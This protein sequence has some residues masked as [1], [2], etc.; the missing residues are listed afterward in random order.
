MPSFLSI[1]TCDGVHL[2]HQKIIKTLVRESRKRDYGGVLVYFPL[3]PKFVFSGETEN[4]LITLPAERESL[5][6]KAGAGRVV[7]LPFDR[8]L[9]VM[10]AES[11]FD[12]VV[13]GEYGA[14]GLVMGRDF[15][16]GKDRR[17]NAEFLEKRCA[18]AGI[19]FKS[20]HFAVHGGHK[21]SSSL[22]RAYLH[23]GHVEEA[24]KCLGRNYSVSGKVVKGAGI[25]RT[26]GFPTANIAADPAKILPP[27]VYAAKAHLGDETFNAVL[28]IGRRPTIKSLGGRLLLEAHILDF[29]RMIYGRKLEVEFLKHIRPE[30]KF[31]SREAL[32]RQISQDISQARKYFHSHDKSPAS[33][34]ARI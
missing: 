2:G 20:V 12:R 8:K 30:K 17:G 9:A 28:N 15:A 22:I 26:L 4:C 3:P 32:Q 27:G 1:G 7:A 25:G 29:D 34:A 11:F 24:N 6:R 16:L 14:R 10:S 21:I 23:N 19:K 5:L 13:V 18:A 31:G 33:L